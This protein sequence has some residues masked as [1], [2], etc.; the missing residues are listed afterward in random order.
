M[1]LFHTAY[2]SSSYCRRG[3]LGN[4]RFYERT[5]RND[6]GGKKERRAKCGVWDLPAELA[7]DVTVS[8]G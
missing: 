8:V 1:I 4:G 5:P 7:D 2:K 6:L 3:I